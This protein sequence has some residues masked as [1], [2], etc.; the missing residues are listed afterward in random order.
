ML[1]NFKNIDF[2]LQIKIWDPDTVPVKF[3][4]F[5]LSINDHPFMDDLQLYSWKRGIFL[6]MNAKFKELKYYFFNT[7]T[8]LVVSESTIYSAYK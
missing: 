3:F 6:I 5:Y 2:S 8:W 4:N 7:G 1:I